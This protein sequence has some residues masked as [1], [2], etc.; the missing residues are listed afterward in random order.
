MEEEINKAISKNNNN[1]QE[2]K[3]HQSS[4]KGL[5]REWQ[6]AMFES[7]STAVTTKC[8]SGS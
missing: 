8:R 6:S 2:Q 5:T 1:T 4:G 7:D 3:L